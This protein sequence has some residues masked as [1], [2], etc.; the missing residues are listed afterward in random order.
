[1]AIIKPTLIE[2][3]PPPEMRAVRYVVRIGDVAIDADDDLTDEILARVVRV[4]SL[5]PTVRVFVA[6]APIHVRGSFDSLACAASDSIRSMVTSSCSSTSVVALR[7]ANDQVSRSTH[8]VARLDD[9]VPV[10]VERVPLD[11]QCS[12]FLG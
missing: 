2:L 3:V 12:K 1:M 5:P 9:V 4:L 11:L 8:L 10:A 6:A 7:P